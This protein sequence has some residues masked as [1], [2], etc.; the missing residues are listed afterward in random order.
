MRPYYQG[1]LDVFCALYAVLNAFQLVHTLSTWQAKRMLSELLV[2]LPVADHARWEDMVY[3]RTDYVWLVEDMFETYGQELFPVRWSRPW[4]HMPTAAP[5]D[6]WEGMSE[7]M[8]K[9]ASGK[10]RRTCVFRFQR[11]MPLRQEPLVSHWTTAD[12]LMGDTL[13][14]FDASMEETAIHL[15]DKTGFATQRENISSSRLLLVEPATVF[16]LEP[17]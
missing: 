14:L 1:K 9:G 5:A 4:H 15:I 7:W 11:F 2:R 13:F 10:S 6:V 17:Y 3:N 8:N 16:L 12:R